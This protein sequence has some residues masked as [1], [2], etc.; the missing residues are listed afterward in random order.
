M[1]PVTG[2]KHSAVDELPGLNIQQ[3]IACAFFS[4]ESRSCA[5][6]ILVAARICGAGK[7]QR[8]LHILMQSVLAN[9]DSLDA[10]V[11]FFKGPVEP[12]CGKRCLFH[13]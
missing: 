3:G 2:V 11:D 6:H 1:R 9:R 8:G 13:V 4:L 5:C 12:A 10:I 7:S